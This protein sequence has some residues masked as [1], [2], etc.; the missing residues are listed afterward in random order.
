MK[1]AVIVTLH[2]P[3]KKLSLD[4]FV[5]QSAEPLH[6]L[7]SLLATSEPQKRFGMAESWVDQ[8][9]AVFGTLAVMW[10]LRN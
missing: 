10:L 2:Q 4:S 5:F 7:S 3:R 6:C 9:P 1:I 8:H